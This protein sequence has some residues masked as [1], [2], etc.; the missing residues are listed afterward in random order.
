M[1][2][3]EVKRDDQLQKRLCMLLLQIRNNIG[4]R[5][6][7]LLVECMPEA[8]DCILSNAKKSKMVV[9]NYNTDS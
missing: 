5:D 6:V 1:I 8:L 4:A 3:K 2:S 7:V 9:Q